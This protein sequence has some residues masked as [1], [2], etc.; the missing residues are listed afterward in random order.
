MSIGG[1]GVA[2]VAIVAI[3][4]LVSSASSPVG[5]RKGHWSSIGGGIALQMS[6]PIYRPGTIGTKPNLHIL[7]NENAKISRIGKRDAYVP[8][9]LC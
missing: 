8:P 1:G 4:M 3:A 7:H 5:E 2:M 6:A 9:F